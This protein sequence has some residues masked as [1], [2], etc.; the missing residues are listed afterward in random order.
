[1]TTA[2]RLSDEASAILRTLGTAPDSMDL[3]ETDAK[4]SVGFLRRLLAQTAQGTSVERRMTDGGY[5]REGLAKEMF[6]IFAK[7]AHINVA[8]WPQQD[9]R[10]KELYRKAV[11]LV[12]GYRASTPTEKEVGE[13]WRH[14]KR[15]TTYKRIGRAHL[16]TQIDLPDDAQVEVY[17]SEADGALWV[18]PSGE[19][20][21]GRFEKIV[22]AAP[23]ARSASVTDEKDREIG[24]LRA[25][26]RV[27]MLR[28]GATDVEI[29]RVL[30]AAPTPPAHGEGELRAAAELARRALDNLMG[31][32]DLDDDDSLEMR[33]MQAL[34]R[35]L[36]PSPPQQEE[37][38]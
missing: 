9:E 1:M 28:Y 16:Q 22:E 33:A 3:S 30:G 17:Q 11:D 27:N 38:Q 31:D 29:D 25:A 21:D 35:A 37:D 10:D 13:V 32:S 34:T 8:P 6:T 4:I 36:S 15:G 18:R 19:F 20:F 2:K 14:K 23:R 5:T 12:L 26:F 7:D 24:R